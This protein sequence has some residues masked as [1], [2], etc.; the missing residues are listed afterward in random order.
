MSE[1]TFHALYVM[2]FLTML[3]IRAVSRG[4]AIRKQ[5]AVRRVESNA[6]MMVRGFLAIPYF[7]A[8]FAYMIKPSLFD[9]ADFWLPEWLR[10]TGVVIVYVGLAGLA[11]VQWALGRNFD[12]TL[13]VRDEHT[14]I[15]HGP[16]RWVRHPMYTVL[17]LLDIGVFLLITN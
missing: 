3:V 17:F 6:N 11:W 15:T 14:L 5:G 9:W 10:W 1:S 8:V 4:Q 2:A 16:Y 13:H 12:T 7:A